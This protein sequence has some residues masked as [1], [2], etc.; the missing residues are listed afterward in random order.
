MGVS[1]Y[2][3]RRDVPVHCKRVADARFVKLSTK[4]FEDVTV[5]CLVIAKLAKMHGHDGCRETFFLPFFATAA[6]R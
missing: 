3:A 4:D 5:T 1:E 6:Y 2:T